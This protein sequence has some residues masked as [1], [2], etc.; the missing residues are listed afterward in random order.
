MTDPRWRIEGECWIWTGRINVDGYG[1]LGSRYAHRVVY[2]ELVGEI[3]DGLHLDHLCRVR[4]CVRPLHLEPVTQRENTL[5]G[6]NFCAVKARQTHCIHGH[7][8]TPA[9]TY[10]RTN[11]TRQCR[12]CRA[13]TQR[14]NRVD[15]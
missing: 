14:R 7:E 12:T 11:G 1:T 10:V 6:Q 15:L 5:R 4:S 9:N 2:E 13:E 3:P 8:F